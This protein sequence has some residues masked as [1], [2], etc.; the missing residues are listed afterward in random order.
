MSAM[1]VNAGYRI[2]I[3]YQDDGLRVRAQANSQQLLQS[4]L[5][6]S[7]Q[8]SNSAR[9]AKKALKYRNVL[10]RMTDVNVNDPAFDA[11]KFL[12]VDWRKTILLEQHA[13]SSLPGDP[14][15]RTEC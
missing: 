14:T 15:A 3:Q 12:G 1:N 8:L 2:R 7:N 6:E 9:I 4:A 13:P 5:D 10:D 11:S